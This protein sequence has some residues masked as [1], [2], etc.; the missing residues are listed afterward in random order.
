[1]VVIIEVSKSRIDLLGAKVGVLPQE[2]LGGLA[3]VIVLRGQMKNFIARLADAR[4]PL[5]VGF[6]VWIA[7][8]DNHG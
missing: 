7:R 8:Y 6:D 5:F 1:L 4:R 2:L 3:V